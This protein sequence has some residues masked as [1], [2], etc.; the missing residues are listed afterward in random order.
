MHVKH[1]I[2]SSFHLGVRKQVTLEFQLACVMANYR[3]NRKVFGILG[4]ELKGI[5]L[6]AKL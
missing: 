4:E 3:R 1:N 2:Y 6:N 5:S